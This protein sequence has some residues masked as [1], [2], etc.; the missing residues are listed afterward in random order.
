MEKYLKTLAGCAAT[1]VILILLSVCTLTY[2]YKNRVTV[3]SYVNPRIMVKSLHSPG[4]VPDGYIR[5]Y[6][7]E[8]T[9]RVFFINPVISGF[10]KEYSKV[11]LAGQKDM[12]LVDQ[13]LDNHMLVRPNE[14]ADIYGGL[15][16]S[17]VLDEK[18][19]AIGFISEITEEGLVKVIACH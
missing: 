1:I 16:G 14:V 11:R 12:C 9:D 8:T 19:C 4:T 13:Q 15:S 18:G 10:V 17:P 5:V 2:V 6:E 7:D 3:A